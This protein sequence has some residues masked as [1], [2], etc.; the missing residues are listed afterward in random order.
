MLKIRYIVS[1]EL[2]LFISGNI[3]QTCL[4]W[5]SSNSTLL[6]H[7][8][9]HHK[10]EFPALRYQCEKCPYASNISSNL[11]TH[12]QVHLSNRPYQCSVCGNRFKALSS[13]NNH[14][15]IHTGEKPQVFGVFI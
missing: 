7:R 6:K 5:F 14:A 9:W 12:M 2:Y 13:L 1:Y 11:Q 15:L 8:M 3:C 10:S 4:K